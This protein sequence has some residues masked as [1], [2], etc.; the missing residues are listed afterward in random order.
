MSEIYFSE[1]TAVF[2]TVFTAPVMSNIIIIDEKRETMEKMKPLL[3]ATMV[4]PWHFI[5][6]FV[7]NRFQLR[8]VNSLIVQF[9]IQ[10]WFRE[11]YHSQSSPKN[12]SDFGL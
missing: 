6:K 8:L 5:F 2:V 11:R 3:A 12:S 1:S 10:R 9:N 7:R 4:C